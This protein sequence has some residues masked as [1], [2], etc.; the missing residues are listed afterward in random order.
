MFCGLGSAVLRNHHRSRLAS[1]F[2]LNVFS[3]LFVLVRAYVMKIARSIIIKESCCI[4][5][6]DQLMDMDD[7]PHGGVQTS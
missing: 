2:K 6:T 1:V 7:Q 5:L 3:D 4:I